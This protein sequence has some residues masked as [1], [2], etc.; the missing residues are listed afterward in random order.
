MVFAGDT[1]EKAAITPD[2]ICVN[3]DVPEKSNKEEPLAGLKVITDE[4]EI[5]RITLEKPEI[6]KYLEQNEPFAELKLSPTKV[7]LK[8]Y[9]KRILM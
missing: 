2:N 7:K 1:E 6:K 5:S 9:G 8:K 4:E 3:S